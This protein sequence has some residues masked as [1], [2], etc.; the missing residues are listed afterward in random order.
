VDDASDNPGLLLQRE[1]TER[2]QEA[3]RLGSPLLQPL[4]VSR[5]CLPDDSDDRLRE[6]SDAPVPTSALWV[7]LASRSGPVGVMTFLRDGSRRQ[8][9]ESDLTLA[10]ELAA[11]AALAIENALA[12]RRAN[13][14]NRVKDEFLA[15]LSHE[16]RTPLNAVLGYAQM[17]S[18]GVL[19][20]ERRR[21]AM[22]VLVRNGTA[23]KQLI[24]DV[25][26][27]S[28]LS[29]GKLRLSAQRVALAQVVD[30]A[31]A[32]VGPASEAKGIALDVK[33]TPG[34]PEVWGDPDRLQQVVW[35]LLSN[36]VK[37]SARG[38]R[39]EVGLTEDGAG[40]VCLEVR[41]DGQ[42]IAASFL[43][44]IFERFTQAD[45]RSSRE[46]GGLGLGLAIVK[47][48]TE[49]HG[50][51]VSAKSDGPGRGSCFRVCLPRLPA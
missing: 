7:P 6:Q 37:F 1:L 15:T 48:L 2:A 35:N 42:G 14:A 38:G 25:L 18:R 26:D 21:D 16:L 23:L 28:R 12:Y 8:F 10:R 39:V 9:G 11:R 31:V 22:A 13:E 40:R 3:M 41:D 46:H 44:H 43:P 24:D 5:R 33:V 19:S 4:V 20:E 29:S 34:I 36:A 49:L 30:A 50:G 47:E 32:T 45:R 51:T 27:M 17:L